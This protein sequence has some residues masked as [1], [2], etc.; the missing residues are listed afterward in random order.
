MINL[1]SFTEHTGPVTTVTAT[2]NGKLIQ[3]AVFISNDFVIESTND[4]FDV[5]HM[6]RFDYYSSCAW[7]TFQW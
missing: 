4:Y 2:K 7:E 1:S 5:D 6:N 3:C